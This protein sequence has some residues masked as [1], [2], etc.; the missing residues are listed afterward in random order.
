MRVIH[1]NTGD[2]ILQTVQN[3]SAPRI[4]DTIS[5]GFEAKT[6][7][8]VD[9]RHFIYNESGQVEDIVLMCSD[10]YVD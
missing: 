9:E 4:G 5:L 1:T 10:F 8:R 7:F 2:T 3:E 6:F